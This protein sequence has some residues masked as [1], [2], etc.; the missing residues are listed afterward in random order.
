[1]I[2]KLTLYFLKALV[3]RN[4]DL[5]PTAAEQAA[6]TALVTKV[7][8]VIDALVVA[9]ATF[10]AAVVDEARPVGSFKK[11]TMVTGTNVA[12]VVVILR[13]LPTRK[14]NSVLTGL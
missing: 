11:G 8:A 7:Q 1:M 9:P 4:Q 5:T 3:K 13:T 6:I 10:E 2:V 14:Y 12:D